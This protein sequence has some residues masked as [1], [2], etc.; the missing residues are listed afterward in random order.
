M[1]GHRFQ[2][3]AGFTLIE[4]V[5]VMAILGL[6][7][8]VLLPSFSRSRAVARDTKR[9][10]DL[11]SVRQALETYR[12]DQTPPIYPAAVSGQPSGIVPNYQST[13][14]VDPLSAQRYVYV[15]L[16]AGIGY[17]LCA[18]LETETT[19]TAPDCPGMAACGT[20]QCNYE[21]KNP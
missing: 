4:V 5:V 21:V 6:L 15:Q 18:K 17:G 12:S 7:V 14:P 3:I 1:K 10:G 20:G 16:S 9:K 8:T 2:I 11:E 13:Y 19:G